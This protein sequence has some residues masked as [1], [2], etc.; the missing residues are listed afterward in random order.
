VAA[1]SDEA[2]EDARRLDA[3][4]RKPT[5]DAALT[6]DGTLEIDETAAKAAG[7]PV[8]IL[9]GTGSPLGTGAAVAVESGDIPSDWP[10]YVSPTG[11]LLWRAGAEGSGAATDGSTRGWA[12]VRP[13]GWLVDAE[14]IGAIL[15]VAELP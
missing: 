3:F 7:L 10:A 6:P 5:L 8:D 11:R 14:D 9:E 1:G 12:Y 4:E 15:Y 13:R 2:P